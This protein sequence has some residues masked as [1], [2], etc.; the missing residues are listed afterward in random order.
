MI[1]QVILE[2]YLDN[3]QCKIC[4]EITLVTDKGNRFM[5]KI[6]QS[7]ED[8][9]SRSYLLNNTCRDEWS[10][11][12]EIASS[13]NLILIGRVMSTFSIH[14]DVVCCLKEEVDILNGDYN[15]KIEIDIPKWKQV[16]D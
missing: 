14:E 4:V 15:S 9:L 2:I 5:S 13:L 16:T 11:A 1:K 8:E 6:I 10:L 7:D 3:V 12:A